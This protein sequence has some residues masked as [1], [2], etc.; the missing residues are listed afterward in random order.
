MNSNITQVRTSPHTCKFPWTPIVINAAGQQGPAGPS[1]EKGLQGQAGPKGD[2]GGL[3]I[4]DANGSTGALVTSIDAAG[5]GVALWQHQLIKFTYSNGLVTL[6]SESTDFTI[7]IDSP[8]VA[9]PTG[10]YDVLYKEA[11]C[12]G[13]PY[14]YFGGAGKTMLLKYST[15]PATHRYPLVENLLG[16]R[17]LE[18]NATPLNQMH[19]RYWWD[20]ADSSS[21]A[22]CRSYPT[23]FTY[24]TEMVY[25]LNL[26]PATSFQYTGSLGLNF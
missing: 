19:G 5:N 6:P 15:T 17:I 4:I 12:S 24:R 26:A 2:A 21:T 8:N 1:G 23:E 16:K 3:Y 7:N 10:N 22:T 20:S 18:G 9:A 14:F 11:D 25:P 13:Q